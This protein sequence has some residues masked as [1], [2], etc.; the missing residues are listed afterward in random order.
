MRG[1]GSCA[2]SYFVTLCFGWSIVYRMSANQYQSEKSPFP[3]SKRKFVMLICG[4]KS[5]CDA[6]REGMRTVVLSGTAKSCLSRITATNCIAQNSMTKCLQAR[7]RV[8][9]FT[10]Q[11]Y[12]LT[13]IHKSRIRNLL[14]IWGGGIFP[15]NNQSSVTYYADPRCYGSVRTEINKIDINCDA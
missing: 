11:Q 2:L 10:F 5:S 7:P 13:C 6:G 9:S 14:L 15:H 3:I 8:C 1:T 4:H 12:R